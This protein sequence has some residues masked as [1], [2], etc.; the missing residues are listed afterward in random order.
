MPVVREIE[1]RW[2]GVECW[3]YDK[4]GLGPHMGEANG[5]D[6]P[7]CKWYTWPNK[8]QIAVGYAIRDWAWAN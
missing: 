3:T 8:A 4:H 1:K 2:P 7:I 6:A 5:I